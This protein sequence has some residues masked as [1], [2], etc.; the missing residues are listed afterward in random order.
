MPKPPDA[1]ALHCLVVVAEERT[2]IGAA[3]RLGLSRATLRR[4]VQA[5]EMQ[6]GRRLLERDEEGVSLTPHGVAVVER[7]RALLWELA[8][9]RQVAASAD[10]TRSVGPIRLAVPDG[11]PLELVVAALEAGRQLFPDALAELYFSPDP[12]VPLR[13]DVDAYLHFGEPP[14]RGAYAT[15]VILRMPERLLA[16]RAYLD[17]HG[18][19]ATAA[20]LDRHALLSWAPPG[21]S[22]RRWPVRG[23]ELDVTPVLSSPDVHLLR[24]LMLRGFGIARLPDAGVPDLDFE[25]EVVALLPDLFDREIALRVLV[26]ESLARTPRLR[27]VM[28]LIESIARG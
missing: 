10:E 9:L 21:E 6:L 19:P 27:A 1:E 14:S 17:A 20:D 26:P 3:R 11:L 25:G 5:L 23:G 28:A 12:L 22:A 7:G 4:R 2:V 24:R 18:V 13:D 8:Q 16:T 15:R